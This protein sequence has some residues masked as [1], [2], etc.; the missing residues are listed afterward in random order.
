MTRTL[1]A[2][3]Q[4]VVFAG[5]AAAISISSIFIAAPAAHAAP[6]CNPQD[7]PCAPVKPKCSVPFFDCDNLPP[8]LEEDP[9][10]PPK[11]PF[12]PCKI[13]DCDN[14]GQ[15]PVLEEVS[16]EPQPEPDPTQPPAGN[17]DDTPTPDPTTD[18]TPAPKDE[19]KTGGTTGQGSSS[20]GSRQV[21]TRTVS[22][23][24][25]ADQTV[26]GTEAQPVQ[27]QD[28]QPVSGTS[29]GSIP[30]FVWIVLSA[31]LSAAAA[32]AVS[33]LGKRKGDQI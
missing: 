14:L 24:A 3:K 15:G 28:G 1:A 31:V 9:P 21:V 20:G 2:V 33:K 17:N 25:P 13:I 16:D 11:P 6:I 7:A 4:S 23:S 32:L 8:V 5:A 12:N 10:T 29:E 19:P 30:N 27:V 22:A 18:D 26:A